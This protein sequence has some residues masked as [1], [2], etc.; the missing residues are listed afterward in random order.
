MAY[1]GASGISSLASD[2]RI[3]YKRVNFRWIFAMFAVKSGTDLE[4]FTVIFG[5]G[6]IYKFIIRTFDF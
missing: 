6:K 5:T 2:T 3:E 4:M 1:P